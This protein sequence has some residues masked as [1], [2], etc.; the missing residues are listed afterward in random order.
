MKIQIWGIGGAGRNILNA[1]I[2][3]DVPTEC[4]VYLDTHLQ[5]LPSARAGAFIQLGKK[6]C[7]GL[8]AVQAEIGLEAARESKN[9]ICTK[10]KD[11]DFLILVAGLGGG[12]G[13]GAIPYIASLA[14]SSTIPTVAIVTLPPA[15]EGHR[16]A[17]R[18][19]AGLVQLQT[20]L[21]KNNVFVHTI[22]TTG[23]NIGT[24]YEFGS[25]PQIVEAVQC[26][27]KRVKTK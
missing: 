11:L 10:L 15:F 5:A 9:C 1:L 22:D 20:V 6:L 4:T 23:Y 8:G 12:V 26:I 27:L 21:G 18:A 7:Q 25:N 24:T 3:N 19:A 2:E 14:Q 17:N 13:S 16:R